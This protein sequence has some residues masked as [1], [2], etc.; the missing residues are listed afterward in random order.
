M[1]GICK[2]VPNWY[3]GW[4]PVTPPLLTATSSSQG[5]HDVTSV[6]SSRVSLCHRLTLMTRRPRGTRHAQIWQFCGTFGMLPSVLPTLTFMHEL[7]TIP[8]RCTKI[9][10]LVRS[11]GA[12]CRI[13][14]GRVHHNCVL[15]LQA[16]FCNTYDSR[17]IPI[18]S[19]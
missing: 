17:T 13:L 2:G 4:L 16:M 12:I 3:G 15:D 9:L 19:Y 8:V 5:H 1:D 11:K 7:G 18:M 6:T 14:L 10:F